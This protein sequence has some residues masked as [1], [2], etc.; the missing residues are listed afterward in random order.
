MLNVFL[1]VKKDQVREEEEEGIKEEDAVGPVRAS[2][3][4]NVLARVQGDWDSA[5]CL[6]LSAA[7]KELSSKLEGK[8]NFEKKNKIKIKSRYSSADFARPVRRSA[9]PFG[10]KKVI[11]K[12][13]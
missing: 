3:G 2:V 12:I 6:G 13:F 10:E 4:K 1:P 8:Y 5:S 9:G 11:R 7:Y